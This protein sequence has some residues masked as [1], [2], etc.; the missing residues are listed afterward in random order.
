MADE[1]SMKPIYEGPSE[2]TFYSLGPFSEF[3]GRLG[4]QNMI[5]P[6][7]YGNTEGGKAAWLTPG[8][9]GVVYS[10]WRVPE[11]FR[12]PSNPH[13]GGTRWPG[14]VKVTAFGLEAKLDSFDARVK[15]EENRFN[16]ERMMVEDHDLTAIRSKDEKSTFFV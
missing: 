13:M 1:I 3:L 15:Q 14:M 16:H 12:L 4:S 10:Y 5:P 6:N 7:G 2:G 11:E 9:V 8:G